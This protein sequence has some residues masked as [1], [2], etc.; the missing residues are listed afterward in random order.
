MRISRTR[1]RAQVLTQPCKAAIIRRRFETIVGLQLLDT[2]NL[3]SI[4]M[5]K[6]L[7][8]KIRITSIGHT[9]G[10]LCAVARIFGSVKSCRLPQPLLPRAASGRF[11]SGS[12]I[13]LSATRAVSIVAPRLKSH[14]K[15]WVSR[16]TE[17]SKRSRL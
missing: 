9:H 14:S 12:L 15:I 13:V 10:A 4:I 6:M 1:E 11:N 3:S 5:N 16:L 7:A 8:K 17:M 2:M